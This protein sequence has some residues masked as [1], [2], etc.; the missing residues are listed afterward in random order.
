[1]LPAGLEL[2][3]QAPFIVFADADLAAAVECAVAA[4]MRNG[5]AACTAANAFHV[6][7]PVATAFA[8]LL[9]ERL[10]DLLLGRGTEPGVHLGPMIR[11]RQARRLQELID[12]AVGRGAGVALPGGALEGP[13]HFVAPAVL[14]DPAPAARV[15]NEEIFGPI[16]PVCRFDREDELLARVN[17]CEQGLA[18]YVH[19]RDLDRALRVGQALDVGMVAVNR[20]RV[21]SVAAPF[22]G[23]KGSGW[24][25]TGGPDALR[26]YL[27][28]R[29]LAI[30]RAA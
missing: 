12:D 23:A 5:G 11:A 28:T 21:S 7:A 30:G 4:K 20:G 18:A 15:M 14:T 24:G 29:Y 13:G 16:A 8:E 22:G 2:G 26:D 6:E 1:L 25:R 9:A 3:G 10:G 19:T 27:E 17:A